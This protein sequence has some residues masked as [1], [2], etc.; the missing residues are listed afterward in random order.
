[1]EVRYREERDKERDKA[2]AQAGFSLALLGVAQRG[3]KYCSTMHFERDTM[4]DLIMDLGF[5]T[6]V[7]LSAPIPKI[8]LSNSAAQSHK[9]VA[10]KSNRATLA[11]PLA[12]ERERERE[13]ESER[14]RERCVSCVPYSHK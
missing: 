3:E 14:E 10:P 4:F 9:S 7:T 2:S 1:V 13:R 8:Y 5:V 6:I 12:R 11:K